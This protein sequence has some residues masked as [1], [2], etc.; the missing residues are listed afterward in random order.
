MSDSREVKCNGFYGSETEENKKFS[1]GMDK[2]K[3]KEDI[4]DP[5]QTEGF[6]KQILVKNLTTNFSVEDKF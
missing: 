2:R 3:G 6:I 4:R 5:I 1:K